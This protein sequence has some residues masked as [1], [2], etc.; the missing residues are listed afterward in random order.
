MMD[1]DIF[2][3]TSILARVRVVA[4]IH[5][6]PVQVAV[7][8]SPQFGISD[9]VVRCWS[10][11]MSLFLFFFD[12]GSKPLDGQHQ[13]LAGPHP[14]SQS[15]KKRGLTELETLGNT[16]M[17]WFSNSVCLQ[18]AEATLPSNPSSPFFLSVCIS[19]STSPPRL[20][21][22]LFVWK[23]ACLKNVSVPCV[24]RSTSPLL[25]GEGG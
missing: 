18:L 4:H 21:M 8:F 1:F 16:F 7:S 2:H 13:G 12:V 3:Q 22:V 5:W 23:L 20:F 24:W 11:R 17:V 6:P 14:L 19:F 10:R 25:G 9:E 15:R